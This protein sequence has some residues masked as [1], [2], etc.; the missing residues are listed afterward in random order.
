[1]FRQYAVTKRFTLYKLNG[2]NA[3]QPA[4]GK[5]EATDPAEGVNHAEAHAPTLL[6]RPTGWRRW[7]WP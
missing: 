1:M 7:R 6:T 4:S 5:T 3:T 2:F